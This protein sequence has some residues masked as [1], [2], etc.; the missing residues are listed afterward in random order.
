MNEPIVIWP[1]GTFDADCL[2][3]S[4]CYDCTYP[5]PHNQHMGGALTGFP[6][7]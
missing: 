1:P 3:L 6:A 4:R 7:Y 2:G 5:Y